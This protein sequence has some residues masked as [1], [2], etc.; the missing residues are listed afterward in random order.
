MLTPNCTLACRSCLE[1]RFTSVCVS[2]TASHH[3][4]VIYSSLTKRTIMCLT[5][6]STYLNN[7]MVCWACLPQCQGICK[8][9]KCSDLRLTSNLPLSTHSSNRSLMKTQ[10]WLR[11]RIQI[12][13]RIKAMIWLHWFIA[14]QKSNNTLKLWLRTMV[15]LYWTTKQ[16]WTK[17]AI[18]TRVTALLW[19]MQTVCVASITS[20]LHMA[21]DCS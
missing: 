11:H 18:L 17:C 1:L 2:K 21:S 16:E 20:A 15:T 13:S 9:M 12:S 4:K 8:A 14:R 6:T 10:S 19:P 7:A 3:R 5:A